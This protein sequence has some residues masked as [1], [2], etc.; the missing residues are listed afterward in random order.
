MP[1]HLNTDTDYEM[2][3]IGRLKPHERNVNQ[4]DFGAIQES[5]EANGFFGALV[6]QRSSRRILAGNHRFAVAQ[7][8]G[9]TELPVTWV[10]VDDE[11]ALR[12]LLAD[13]RTGRLGTDNSAALAE[14]LAE[15]AGTDTGLAGTGYDGDAL[16]QIIS[17]L[18]GLP[19][20]DM[21]PSMDTG[22][23]RYKEQYGVIVICESEGAQE[24]VYN[25]LSAAGHKCRVVVT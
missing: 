13:N 24:A 20:D 4:G 7:K 18:A 23:G 25:E 8:L 11:T 15:L 22:E 2:V 1:K 14:L 9:Y 17:D 12:I 3:P 5:I 21:L 16:D 6:C 10:D 19:H